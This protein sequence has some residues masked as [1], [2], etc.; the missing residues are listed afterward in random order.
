VRRPHSSLK[1]VLKHVLPAGARERVYSVELISKRWAEVVGHE[2]ARR[3]EPEALSQGV[4]TVRVTD[5]VWGKMIYKLQD[6]IIPALNRAVGS[7]LVRRINFTKRS[8]LEHEVVGP[9]EKMRDPEPVEPP[10][11]VVAAAAG[12][13]EPELKEI[14]LRSAAHYLRAR[15]R[16][17][18]ERREN[19]RS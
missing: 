19:E 14:V 10:A 15:E 5:P 1:E 12:I 16:K 13:E 3:S 17:S 8:R 7:S 9:P 18:Q 2:L 6:R 4:L 11:S